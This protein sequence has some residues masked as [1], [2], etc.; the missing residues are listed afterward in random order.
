MLVYENEF[1]IAG[2]ILSGCV[3]SVLL[4]ISFSG[5]SVLSARM[6]IIF[7]TNNNAPHKNALMSFF[8]LS[9]NHFCLSCVRMQ[10]TVW[11]PIRS[12]E[13][14]VFFFINRMVIIGKNETHFIYTLFLSHYLIFGH[15]FLFFHLD[16][17]AC[18]VNFS[19]NRVYECGLLIFIKY[20]NHVRSFFFL[21][22]A[23][24]ECE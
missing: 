17:C 18:V 20:R 16:A 3:Q 2:W 14:V 15:T 9:K 1:N 5:I 13:K 21:T 23:L 6:V 24:N 19:F 4:H 12:Q 11:I 10:L 22:D 7:Y 8:L